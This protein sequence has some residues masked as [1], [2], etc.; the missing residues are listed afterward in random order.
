MD[1]K[2]Y[3]INLKK[4][5]DS[6]ASDVKNLPLTDSR[7]CYISGRDKRIW[8]NSE[9]LEDLRD[10]IVTSAQINSQ[11]TVLEVGCAAGFIAKLLSPHVGTYEGIDVSKNAI[12]IAKKLSLNNARFSIADGTK[13]PYLQDYFDSSICY[14]VLTN[15]P[16]FEEVVPIIKEMVRVTK[17]KGKILIGSIPDQ[18]R[19][20]EYIKFV[21]IYQQQLAENSTDQNDEV[22]ERVKPN[23]FFNY[24]LQLFGNKK[25][26]AVFC[27]YFSKNDFLGLGEILGLD[28]II[29]KVHKKNPYSDYRFNV[30]YTK[31]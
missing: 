27:Y 25:P 19:S 16:T 15:F 7:L 5:I 11:S 8:E 20:E 17:P 29:S 21:Q 1:I 26:P 6:R 23:R 13:L 30:T 2:N 9:R 14:D 12:S 3:K 24:F 4:C 10:S 22:L 28:T 31:S 18:D